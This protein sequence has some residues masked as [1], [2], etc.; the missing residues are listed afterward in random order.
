V[1]VSRLK[2]LFN[3]RPGLGWVD[4]RNAEAQLRD[5][6]S[7]DQLNTRTRSAMSRRADPALPSIG[8]L[9]AESPAPLCKRSQR[10]P[11]ASTRGNRV[12]TSRGWRRSTVGRG[13]FRGRRFSVL[14]LHCPRHRGPD[15]LLVA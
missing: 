8:R 7:L 5:F 14:L 3:G 12:A 9:R 1:P 6:E 13:G 10:G 15:H 4:Q 11:P 2:R